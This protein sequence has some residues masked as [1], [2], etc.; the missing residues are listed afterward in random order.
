MEVD[1]RIAII[2]Q[3]VVRLQFVVEDLKDKCQ[4][5]AHKNDL[6][7]LKTHPA[8]TRKSDARSIAPP[9]IEDQFA[10]YHVPLHNQ[11]YD[12]V[13]QNIFD[14][15]QCKCWKKRKTWKYYKKDYAYV[16][17]LGSLINYFFL[18]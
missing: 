5:E 18:R 9:I 17:Q 7:E 3:S 11:K 13:D 15:T 2:S 4:N 14:S 8:Y 16:A 10:K 12:K 1:I 6:L